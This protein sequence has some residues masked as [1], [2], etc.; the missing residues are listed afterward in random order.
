[1]KIFNISGSAFHIGEALGQLGK[2]AW[3]CKIKHTALWKQL[4]PFQDSLYMLE[5]KKK[6]QND[7]PDIWQEIMGLAKGLDESVMTVFLW[8]CR[9][10]V[11]SSTADGC[12]TIIGTDTAGNMLVAHNEDGLPELMDDCFLANVTTENGASFLSFAY[13]ASL[14]GHTFSVNCFGIVNTV[15]NL[16]IKNRTM[17][18]PRQVLAR[19]VLNKT[20]I[21]EVVDTLLYP[22]SGGFH[23]T[24]VQKKLGKPTSSICIEA[25]NKQSNVRIIESIGLH[26]NH[27][28]YKAFDAQII[29]TSSQER[30]SR[31]ESIFSPKKYITPLDCLQALSDTQNAEFPIY[32]TSEHD[33]DNENTIATIIFTVQEGK[34]S[35]ELYGQDRNGCENK[36][37]VSLFSE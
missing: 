37:E 4:Q 27:V 29:T 5:L 34:V 35:W 12:T 17:G 21:Q 28:V 20:D 30:Q 18:Y 15:N 31:L 9:G 24:L 8:N 11:L 2:A 32:R 25:I 33:S 7:F 14:C 6:V 10:D 1:M 16:R 19:E 13:P 3:H 26:A 36:G 23:H 22:R